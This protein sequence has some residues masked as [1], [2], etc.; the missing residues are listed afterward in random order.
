MFDV[1]WVFLGEGASIIVFD[2]TIFVPS[3]RLRILLK[4]RKY[5]IIGGGLQ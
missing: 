4:I 1:F 3:Y 5:V 2:K